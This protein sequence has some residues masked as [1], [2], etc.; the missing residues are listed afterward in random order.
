MFIDDILYVFLLRLIK[1]ANNPIS[2]SFLRSEL[3]LNFLKIKMPVM[4]MSNLLNV[5]AKMVMMS[6]VICVTIDLVLMEIDCTV[7]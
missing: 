3:L 6:I 1:V 2:P 7:S 5:S 4:L